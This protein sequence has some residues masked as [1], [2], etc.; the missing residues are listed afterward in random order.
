[1]ISLDISSLCPVGHGCDGL[2]GVGD[3]GG[4][5]GRGGAGVDGG[6]LHVHRV[7]MVGMDSRPVLNVVVNLV[8]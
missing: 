5:R 1:M 3:G 2:R 8:E 7:S 6:L 4:D